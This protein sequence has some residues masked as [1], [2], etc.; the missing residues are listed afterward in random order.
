MAKSN[1]KKINLPSVSDNAI[2][3]IK[4]I[5]KDEDN[6]SFMRIYVE[7]G[8]CSGLSYK[9]SIDNVA[10]AKED[11]AIFEYKKKRILVTDKVSLGFIKDSK[12]D[13]EENLTGAQFNIDNPIAKSKC[14]C[15]SSFSI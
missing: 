1:N 8:G 3:K 10:D 14:G 4:T 2:N 12:I 7:S 15:G 13:W 6:K 11:I 5:L 9:F